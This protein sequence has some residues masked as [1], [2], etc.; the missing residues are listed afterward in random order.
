MRMGSPE[1]VS[2]FLGGC[3]FRKSRSFSV[4]VSGKFFDMCASASVN[5]S[6]TA[7]VKTSTR[8]KPNK[9]IAIIP[10][11]HSVKSYIDIL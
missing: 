10:P 7:F 6:V 9:A 2:F 1:G 8:W 4:I 11:D 3:T 5:T